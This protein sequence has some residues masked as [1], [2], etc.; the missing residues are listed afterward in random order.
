MK[1]LGDATSQSFLIACKSDLHDRRAVSTKEGKA[2]AKELGVTW[3]G[4]VSSKTN[5]GVQRAFQFWA[6]VL[7]QMLAA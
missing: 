4:E 6:P 3:K 1:K 7:K 5:K 2:L